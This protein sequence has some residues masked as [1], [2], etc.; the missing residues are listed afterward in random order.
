MNRSY[1]KPNDGC[2]A[3]L[4]DLRRIGERAADGGHGTT[5]IWV[6]VHDRKNFIQ[7]CNKWKINVLSIE[8]STL[9][10]FTIELPFHN[11]RHVE[12]V[13]IYKINNNLDF[14]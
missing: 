11:Y 8:E 5:I 6:G 14:F 1:V 12:D 7:E 13:K 10:K 3:Y 4:D 2:P 9:S